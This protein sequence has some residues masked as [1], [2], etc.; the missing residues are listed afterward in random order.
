MENYLSW[1]SERNA[2]ANE[3]AK[4]IIFCTKEV[5]TSG[6]AALYMGLSKNYL[7]KLTSQNKIPHYKPLGKMCFFNRLEIEKWLQSNRV[8]TDDEISQQAQTYCTK[9]GGKR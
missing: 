2:I 4:Q 6:E 3:V 5:L 7:Y 1:T 8:A 9:K